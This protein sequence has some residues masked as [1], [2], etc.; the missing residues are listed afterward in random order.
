MVTS[1]AFVSLFAAIG[2]AEAGNDGRWDARLT[3]VSGEVRVIAADDGGP[4]LAEAGLPLD[5]GDRIQVGDGGSAEI[6][7][8]GTSVMSLGPGADFTLTALSKA[9][10]QFALAFGLLLAKIQHLGEPR[11]SVRAPAAVAAVRGTELGVS[12]GA[13]GFTRV[14]VFDEGL[15]DVDGVFG[16]KAVLRPRQES[17]AGFGAKSSP[18]RP[19]KFFTSR[20]A[21]MRA[22]A[23]RL[24][25]IRKGW[26]ALTPEEREGLRHDELQRLRAELEQRQDE[27]RSRQQRRRAAQQRLNRGERAVG[28]P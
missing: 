14:A 12:V 18:E 7:L 27:L 10:A 17:A 8:D 20:R 11:L 23:A 19:M 3:A 6:A 22:L 9:K 15:V 13:A 4:A 24:A 16:G 28:H 2:R 26:K 1:I 5:E 21:A 25:T